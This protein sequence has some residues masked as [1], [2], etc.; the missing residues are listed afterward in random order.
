MYWFQGIKFIRA[1]KLSITLK[2]HSSAIQ[3]S[4]ASG[5]AISTEIFTM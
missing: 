4:E 5:Y 1:V 2:N 3:Y